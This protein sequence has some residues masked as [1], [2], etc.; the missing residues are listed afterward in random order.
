LSIA[1][2]AGAPYTAEDVGRLRREPLVNVER[3]RRELIEK[4]EG[5]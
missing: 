3:A 4:M 2:P 5:R 1:P